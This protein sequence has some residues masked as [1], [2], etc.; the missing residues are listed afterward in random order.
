MNS[1]ARPCSFALALA[2][3]SACPGDP[4]TTSD[5]DPASSTGATAADSTTTG[6]GGA[7]TTVAEP[8]ATAEPTTSSATTT[9]TG[10]TTTTSGPEEA[11][12]WLVPLVSPE[13]ASAHSVDI[14]EQGDVVV[15][16]VF[17]GTLEL[18]GEVLTSAG[19]LDLFVARWT[20]AGELLWARRF[21]GPGDEH[22][23]SVSVGSDDRLLLVAEFSD[24]L[25]LPGLAP[26]VSLGLS[27]I[28]VLQL[29]ADGAP[30]WARGFGG[31]GL[32]L[33]PRAVVDGAGDIILSAA[34]EAT[35]DLGGGPLAA[36]DA[37]DLLLA[38]LDAS[39]FHLWS[40]AFGN[41]ADA[42]A[43]DLSVADDGDIAV[44]GWFANAIDLGGGPFLD[45]G[46]YLAVFDGDSG[47]HRWSK[48]LG[49]GNS[50]GCGARFAADG[51][52]LLSGWFQ[53]SI[54]FGTGPALATD[55][56]AD[57]FAARYTADGDLAWAGAHGGPKVD[58]GCGV[59]VGP[60]PGWVLGGTFSQQ[61]EFG[62]ELL[63]KKTAPCA[64]LASLDDHGDHRWSLPLCAGGGG[65]V[66][67]IAAY[68]EGHVVFLARFAGPVDLF[69]Q[70]L[71]APAPYGLVAHVPAHL[72][73]P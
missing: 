71:D 37:R 60:G 47:E 56:D 15:A 20:A 72:L 39:G 26:L 62:G 13:G 31:P 43:H 29:T 23:T 48:Q 7:A 33:A 68:P 66:D 25:E 21:G 53:G 18:G 42:A 28:L 14:A 17:G 6:G 70:S 52:V 51:G 1:L 57:Y 61:I 9:T 11:G 63:T 58:S 38:K 10:D 44:A 22:E 50:A 49:S 45:G 41:F 59:A 24:T 2:L 3:V 69:G 40:K 64:F 65:G 36:A 27:D 8:T 5:G 30:E 54:D 55:E 4:A 32:E 35:I 67:R 34:F 16:G 19:G 46:A 73:E 12:L